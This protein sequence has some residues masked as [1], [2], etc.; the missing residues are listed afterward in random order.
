[1]IYQALLVPSE[2]PTSL[3]EIKRALL[4]Y[5][6]V[7]IADPNDRDI[8]PPNAF[9]AAVIGMP[10]FGFN[11]G[12]VRPIGKVARYDEDTQQVLDECGAAVD[13]GLMAVEGTYTREHERTLTIGAVRLGGYPLDPR[14]VYWL[15]R[16]MAQDPELLRAA[17]CASGLELTRTANQSDLLP[18]GIGDGAINDLPA[19]PLVGDPEVSEREREALT[20]IARARIA[21]FIK[22][23]GYCE[24]KNLV[25]VVSHDIY[26]GIAERVFN[27]CRLVLGQPELD[28][29]MVRAT[30][31][32]QLCH[33]EYL[34]DGRLDALTVSEV[35]RLRTTA[36]GEQASAR[37]QVFMGMR[38]LARC[39]LDDGDFDLNARKLVHT[40]RLAASAV[41][42][43]RESLG[44]QIKCDLGAA[45]LAG[46]PTLVGLMSQLESPLASIGVTLA[47]GGMWALNKTKEYVP[48]LKEL[49]VKEAE[50]KRGAG[51]ALHGFYARI[52]QGGG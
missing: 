49:R 32:L 17:Y 42:R 14:F 40:Y 12:S 52:G 5:D 11:A 21:T 38:A 24:A 7:I 1:M 33:E 41:A 30:R 51:M 6:R 26:G 10:L 35:I 39:A 36:W 27:N 31:I 34:I 45:V 9:T 44:V 48:Q 19:L 18:A 28:P 43:E 4:T 37:E 8:I 50:M 46:G 22:F 25:P 29:Q 23:A 15:Y 20:L 13:Q 47:A 2:R 3:R 16:S